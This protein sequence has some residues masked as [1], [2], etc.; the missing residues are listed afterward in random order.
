MIEPEVVT[1]II[2]RVADL[3]VVIS[4]DGIV[5]GILANPNFKPKEALSR[6]EGARLRDTLTTESAEKF[7]GRLAQFLNDPSGVRPVELNH[8]STDAFDSFPVRYSFHNV[9][10]DGSILLMGR[11]LRPLAEMQQQLV[12]AQIT[13]E[14]DYEAR[15]AFDTQFRV[16]MASVDDAMVFVSLPEGMVSDCNPAA[17]AMLGKQGGDLVGI[18][19]EHLFEGRAKGDLVDQL[20]TLATEGGKPQIT[21]K[22]RG[23]GRM[24]TVKPTLFR[25]GGDQAMLCRVLSSNV[26]SL[27]SD[28]LHDNLAGLYEKGVDPIIFVSAAGQILS[29]N[30]AFL[31]LADVT[32]GRALKG[33]SLSDFL[34]R[35]SVDLNVMLDNAARSGLM[36]AY[37]T[38]ITG[39]FGAERA[40]EIATTH[41]QTGVDPVFAMVVRDISRHDTGRQDTQQLGEVDMQSVIELIGSQSLRDIVAK[42][43]DVVE[44]MCIETAVELTSNNRVAAAEMLGLSRQSLYV[45]LRKYGLLKTGADDS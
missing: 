31:N 28:S 23:A 12:A 1:D 7:D 40:V 33:R 19:L 24:V 41:V 9:G 37:T 3:G 13:L 6:F 32:H 43:T 35:G 15:R 4:P 42:T 16:L 21:L 11:D 29:A 18:S 34:S 14:K 45:K 22:A 8:I 44:K 38:K 25:S 5:L 10:S 27:R 2:S 39:E 26:E 30:E 20:V 36:R 17:R